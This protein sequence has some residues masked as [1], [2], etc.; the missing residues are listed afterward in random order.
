MAPEQGFEQSKN[1]SPVYKQELNLLS[2]Y[3]QE[4]RVTPEPRITSNGSLELGSSIYPG[5]ALPT[6]K[7]GQGLIDQGNI[8]DAR[9]TWQN[10]R[11]SKE[12][13]AFTSDQ[14]RSTTLLEQA[15]QMANSGDIQGAQ[16]LAQNGQA[17]AGLGNVENWLAQ[18][19]QRHS[20]EL[21]A[22]G[23]QDAAIGEKEL[24]DTNPVDEL[25]DGRTQAQYGW[26]DISTAQAD[27]GDSS[28]TEQAASRWYQAGQE[29]L[30]QGNTQTGMIDMKAGT[31]EMQRAHEQQLFGEQDLEMGENN[32]SQGRR[33][34]LKG[35]AN[36]LGVDPNK[37]GSEITDPNQLKNMVSNMTPEQWSKFESDVLPN[38]SQ[39][40]V[41]SIEGRLGAVTAGETPEQIA[42]GLSS[43]QWDGLAQTFKQF[44]NGNFGDLNTASLYQTSGAFGQPGQSNSPPFED[45]MS[46]GN[47]SWLTG[48]Q[49]Q[50]SQPAAVAV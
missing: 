13:S 40:L 12:E 23:K 17:E 37:I 27:F 49:P 30:A 7:P 29:A 39:G 22:E 1:D 10:G 24:K 5:D 44:E 19:D 31:L 42:Q 11:E 9:A 46:S 8:E 45:W 34:E 21:A 28:R 14:Q 35:I 48:N 41:Q 33:E 47:L 32:I 4:G 15:Q 36:D 3:A 6:G 43:Q 16:A 38:A 20:T 2:L 25:K 50:Y 26:N 18:G